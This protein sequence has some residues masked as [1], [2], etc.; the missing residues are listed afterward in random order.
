MPNIVRRVFGEFFLKDKSKQTLK[1]ANKG[2]T[3]VDKSAKKAQK[4]VKGL[5]S[6]MKK[7]ASILTTGLLLVGL[8]TAINLVGD[9]ETSLTNVFTLLDQETFTKF[10]KNLEKGALDI[11]KQFGFATEQ[12]NKALFDTISAGVEAG[13]AINF[14]KEASRLAIGGVTDISV[15]VDGLTSVMNA[16]GKESFNATEAANVFFTTQKFGKTTVAALASNI[17]QVAPI[18]NAAGF[19]F[20]ETATALSTLTLAGLSTEEATTGLKAIMVS[21]IKPASQ[22]AIEFAKLG[23]KLKDVKGEIKPLGTILADISKKTKG[24]ATV[25]GKLFPNVRALGAAAAFASGKI[26]DYDK[27]LKATQNDTTSLNDAFAK[28]SKTFNQMKNIFT[29]NIRVLVIQIGLKFL[30]ILITLLDILM[31]F[32]KAME[33]APTRM[34]VI[35]G[36]L[37]ALALLIKALV[38]PALI[39]MGVAM[40]AALGPFGLIIIGITILVAIIVKFR[41]QIVG[42]FVAF[43]NIIVGLAVDVWNFIKPFLTLENAI[44]VLLGPIGILLKKFGILSKVMG[45]IKGLFSGKKTTLEIKEAERSRVKR[46]AGQSNVTKVNDAIITKTGKVIETSAQDNIIATKQNVTG[47]ITGG[48]NRS[49]SIKSIVDKIEINVAS[50]SEIPS[51]IKSVV[52]KALNDLSFELQADTGLL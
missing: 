11:Q 37:S 32:I 42:A 13:N 36:A 40:F 26:K 5:S 30:P 48:M 41:K 46:V 2:L 49:I 43:K 50:S 27:I 24:N 15:A 3:K 35:T 29:A 19:S 22:S 10:G 47:G 6:Q 12:T 21:V 8:T 31:S 33:D 39:K 23:I 16:Y 7:L 28:Q 38:I 14:M 1:K 25:L 51:Q 9:F 17:G 34:V 52:M 4:S 20:N 45:G 18:A 44:A